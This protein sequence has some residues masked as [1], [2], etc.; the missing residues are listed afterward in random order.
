VFHDSTGGSAPTCLAQHPTEPELFYSAGSRINTPEKGIALW[1]VNPS[2]WTDYASGSKGE[3]GAPSKRS[4]TQTATIQPKSYLQCS[5]GVSS[6]IWASPSTLV[7]GGSDH[8]L[9]IFDLERSQMSESIL[10]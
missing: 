10:T 1:E 5:G 4:K 6:M 2:E 8:Q 9:K 3:M 7:V